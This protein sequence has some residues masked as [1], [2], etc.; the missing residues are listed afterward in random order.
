MIQKLLKSYKNKKMKI[1]FYLQALLVVLVHTMVYN[2]N[3]H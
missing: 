3:N 1:L 2:L